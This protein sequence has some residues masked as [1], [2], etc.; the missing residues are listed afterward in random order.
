MILALLLFLST[1]PCVEC[2]TSRI[3]DQYG[4]VIVCEICEELDPTSH[5]VVTSR[6]T[7]RPE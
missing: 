6:I 3:V 2:Y 4:K 1:L 5:G 7:C